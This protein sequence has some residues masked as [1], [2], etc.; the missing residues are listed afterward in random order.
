MIE[1]TAA[2]PRET[3]SRLTEAQARVL[4][5]IGTYIG[6][7]GYPPTRSEIAAHFGFASING[8]QSHLEALQRAGKIALAPNIARGIR[9]LKI[10][11]LS[12]GPDVA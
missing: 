8:A 2:V 1:I 6:S 10:P 3:L 12:R 5:F 9:L 4:A 7:N 11:S